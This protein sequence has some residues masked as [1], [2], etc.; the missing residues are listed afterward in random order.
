M[1]HDIANVSSSPVVA[2]WSFSVAYSILINILYE[3][4]VICDLNVAPFRNEEPTEMLIVDI[5]Q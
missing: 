2:R 4:N 5:K 3:S 1:R